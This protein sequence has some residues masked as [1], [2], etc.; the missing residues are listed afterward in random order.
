MITRLKKLKREE[1]EPRRR[2]QYGERKTERKPK[3]APPSP[4]SDEK[5][6]RGKEIN[7][8]ER[9]IRYLKRRKGSKMGKEIEELKTEL[10]EIS[11][12][13]FRFKKKSLPNRNKYHRSKS[14]KPRRRLS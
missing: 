8:I 11:K 12:K 5:R 6:L 9:R 13:S 3:R 2:E 4:S 1:K 14:A 7:K 10:D